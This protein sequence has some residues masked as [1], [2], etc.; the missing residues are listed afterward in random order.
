[1]R[2]ALVLAVIFVATWSANAASWPVCTL[3]QN[4][5]CAVPQFNITDLYCVDPSTTVTCPSSV[6]GSRVCIPAKWDIVY[7]CFNSL[8]CNASLQATL[9]GKTC[10]NLFSGVCDPYDPTT[11]TTICGMQ[12]RYFPSTSA[13]S[14][15]AAAAIVAVL[16][17]ALAL[18]L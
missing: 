2:V 4:V 16:A 13:A 5:Q 15:S 14:S 11:T 1:M 8:Q 18:L 12:A 17:S 6:Y 7:R 3:A 9:A 10:R